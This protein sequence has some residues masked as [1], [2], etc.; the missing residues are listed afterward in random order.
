MQSE[1][2]VP[3]SEG[4]EAGSCC[5]SAAVRG[6]L[7][8]LPL[9]LLGRA[10]AGAGCQFPTVGSSPCSASQSSVT[11]SISCPSTNAKATAATAPPEAGRARRVRWRSMP[12]NV[13]QDEK[14]TYRYYID[15]RY[16]PDS[17]VFCKW[18]QP[19]SAG[20]AD[21]PKECEKFRGRE[22]PAE[23]D[24][25]SRTTAPVAANRHERPTRA[26]TTTAAITRRRPLRATRSRWRSHQHGR[27][28][29]VSGRWQPRR[30][31][32][33]SV[34]VVGRSQRTDA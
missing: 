18:S 15:G 32:A 10:R 8:R 6:L 27:L 24:L 33:D 22:R 26:T 4:L 21:Q 25:P 5:P 7:G 19:V 23:V 1:Q 14:H 20:G 16:C 29:V 11:S 30:R 2:R 34:W 12:T 9:P 17:Q 3:G 28:P 31:R 13:P